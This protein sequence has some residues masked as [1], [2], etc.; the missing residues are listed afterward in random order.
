MILPLWKFPLN[1]IYQLIVQMRSP[2]WEGKGLVKWASR[3]EVWRQSWIQ[4]ILGSALLLEGGAVL[5]T[6]CGIVGVGDCCDTP[7]PWGCGMT[8]WGEGPPSIDTAFS[9]VLWFRSKTQQASHSHL[10][11]W[12]SRWAYSGHEDL[13]QPVAILG[14]WAVDTSRNGFILRQIISTTEPQLPYQWNPGNMVPALQWF[15]AD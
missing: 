2:R 8:L 6:G 14:C 7:P 5:H 1:C 10:G 9:A 3:A 11:Q 15:G 4:A 12:L 13:W